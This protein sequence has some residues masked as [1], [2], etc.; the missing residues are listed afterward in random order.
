ME[1][2]ELVCPHC[3]SDNLGTL[4]QATIWQT[5]AF[6]VGPEAEDTFEL[7]D[8]TPVEAEW[9]MYDSEDVGDTDTVGWFCR[10]CITTW[11]SETEQFPFVRPA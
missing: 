3:G 4:E 9:E 1:S 6:T 10:G 11:S 2:I 5:C 8:G 7:P